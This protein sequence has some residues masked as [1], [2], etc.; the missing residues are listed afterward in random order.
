MDK[1]NSNRTKERGCRCDYIFIFE[2]G[3]EFGFSYIT[4]YRGKKKIKMGPLTPTPTMDA[5]Y[6]L[7]EEA[8]LRFLW[9]AL[10]IFAIS[11]FLTSKSS[12]LHALHLLSTQLYVFI[13]NFLFSFLDFAS[14]VQ[15]LNLWF[16]FAIFLSGFCLMATNLES[17]IGISYFAIWV[18]F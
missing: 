10:C 11:Y 14:S 4:E 12:H 16:A 17:F 8:K 3:K 7:I 5:I 18:L 15:S 2:G 9:W 13:V 6:D 1:T